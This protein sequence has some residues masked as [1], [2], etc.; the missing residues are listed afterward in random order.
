MTENDLA[1]I[2]GF[3]DGEGSATIRMVKAGNGKRYPRVEA[4]L[5]QN[6][7]AVLDWVVDL[8]G[9]GKVYAKVDP[10]TP[11]VNHSYQAFHKSGRLFLTA[12][13]PYLKVKKVHVGQILDEVGRETLGPLE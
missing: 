1:Y 9:F 10:R 8:F 2:A 6:D 12:I 5:S 4:R 3:F 11:N 13:E 7:R